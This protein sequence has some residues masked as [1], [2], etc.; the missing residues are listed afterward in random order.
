MKFLKWLVSILGTPPRN[1]GP[2]PKPKLKQGITLLVT[3]ADGESVSYIFETANVSVTERQKP[4]PMTR[5]ALDVQPTDCT[6][7]NI[8]VEMS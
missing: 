5:G 6:H 7:M 3:D 8:I 1:P 4:L 2:D